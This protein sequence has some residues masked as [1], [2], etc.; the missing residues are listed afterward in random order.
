MFRKLDLFLSSGQ[1]PETVI[2]SISTFIL[3]SGLSV[4][5]SGK[6]IL[7]KETI[8][9]LHIFSSQQTPQQNLVA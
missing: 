5:L 3:I 7:F 4:L 1:S 6:R 8:F 2:R 9:E